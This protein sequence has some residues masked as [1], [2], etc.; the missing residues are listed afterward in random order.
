M[1]HFRILIGVLLCAIFAG[2]SQ[3]DTGNVG[4]ATSMGQVKPE[5]LPA[6]WHVTWFNS[7]KEISTKEML[8]TMADMKPQTSDKITLTDLDVDLYVQVDPGRVVDIVKRWPADF[9]KVEKEDGAWVGSQYVVR[10]AREAIYNA[11]T[12]HKSST[13]HTERAELSGE[14]LKSLQADLDA[15]AGKGWF[16]V[17]SANVRNL[18]TDPALEKNIKDAANAALE[19]TKKDN[20]IMVARKEAERQAVIAQGQANQRLIIAQ[21]EA[22]ANEVIAQSLTPQLLRARELEKWNGALPTH[23]LGNGGST[24]LIGK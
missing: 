12:K 1:T 22:K 21:G 24:F 6:G 11:V 2:C 14:I 18:V 20:E 8:I 23:Q 4:V 9:T 19:V 10:Q 17:R 15:S 5:T 7:V 16:M 3:I 13:V